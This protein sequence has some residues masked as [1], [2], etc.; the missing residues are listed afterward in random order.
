M[1]MHFARPELASELAR[2]LR[3]DAVVGGLQH[4]LFL[5]APRGTGLSTFLRRDL[6]PQLAR[7]G[8][9]VVHVELSADRRRDGGQLIV[10]AIARALGWQ[11]RALAGSVSKAR[12]AALGRAFWPDAA[13]P[14]P[15]TAGGTTLTDAICALQDLCARPVALVIDDAH[16]ALDSP[17]GEAAMASLKQASGELN[18][19]GTV[20]LQL[21]LA[22]S[23]RDKLLRLLDTAG[24]PFQGATIH[25]LPKLGVPYVDHVVGLIE[26][27]RPEL[28]PV[29]GVLLAEAFRAFRQRPG[30]FGAA[31]AEALNP[32]NDA[33]GR[34][35]H[36]VRAAAGREQAAE[37]ARRRD[38]YLGLRPLEQAVLGRLLEEGRRFRPDDADTQAFCQQRC[39]GM[40]VSSLEVI[41][42]LERLRDHSPPL[43]W[44]S[45]RGE[46][47]VE[48]PG[49]L[50]WYQEC[51]RS[52]EWPP[53]EAQASCV[54][55]LLSESGAA[56]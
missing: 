36:Q 22:G 15:G 33:E 28:R 10:D 51:S 16:H 4:G 30:S 20:R 6:E 1:R 52:G 11:L 34:F 7:A 46:Y 21:V 19:S 17:P 27:R 9:V 37:T 55:A 3:G 53:I 56:G 39:P 42:A 32:L 31:I 48:D 47:A 50:V 35:E 23:H 26:A 29:N 49:L 24:A 25:S 5:A 54:A 14:Q 13:D 45:P 38:D 18:R 43:V 8:A 12:L 44:R 40:S 2:Q 41:A